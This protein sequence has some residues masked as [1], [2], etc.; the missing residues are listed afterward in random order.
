MVEKLVLK[1]S[2][3][4]E[5]AEKASVIGMLADEIS[6]AERE[7]KELSEYC[8]ECGRRLDETDHSHS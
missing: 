2:L 5:I 1:K 3:L 7:I 4:V 6:K 8:S